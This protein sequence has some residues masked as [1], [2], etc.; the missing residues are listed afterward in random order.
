MRRRR[1]NPVV[2]VVD[3]LPELRGDG[4]AGRMTWCSVVRDDPNALRH[5]LVD[6]GY[7]GIAAGSAIERAVISP[8]RQ[9]LTGL[10]SL[11]PCR[12]RFASKRR[13]EGFR[14]SDCARAVP[15]PVPTSALENVE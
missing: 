3:P 12:S 10:T 1:L 6:L 2:V 14:S 13:V 5:A 8:R 15:T 7:S 9:S 4:R 11:L